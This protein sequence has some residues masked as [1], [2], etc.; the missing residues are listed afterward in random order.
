M[1]TTLL[2]ILILLLS[3]YGIKANRCS[4]AADK[5]DIPHIRMC[6]DGNVTSDRVILDTHEAED[7]GEITCSCIV[8]ATSIIEIYI[9]YYGEGLN[10]N[11]SSCGS[12]VVV[13]KSGSVEEDI[14]YQC[15]TSPVRTFHIRPVTITWNRGSS[16]DSKY[17]LNVTGGVIIPNTTFTISCV[18][19][20]K[21]STP[22][23]TSVSTKTET[24]TR[25]ESTTNNVTISAQESP[26][27]SQRTVSDLGK[28]TTGQSTV[29][30]T[31]S[32]PGNAPPQTGDSLP[33]IIVIPAAAGGLILIIIIIIIVVCCSLFNLHLV[34]SGV[35]F[36]QVDGRIEEEEEETVG[37]QCNYVV[38]ASQDKLQL[39][40]TPQ[41][42]LV[43]T[44][45][46]KALTSPE[47]LDFDCK[48]LPAFELHS[49]IGI[50]STVTL[51]QDIKLY[52]DN[53]TGCTV[54]RAGDEVTDL[55][56]IPRSSYNG[57]D[58]IDR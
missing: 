30:T 21:T 6:E 53:V 33:L 19:P 18:K 10:P 15:N 57:A 37:P 46:S 48:D 36:D 39:N 40:V 45:I 24:T 52:D 7:T 3:V 17:C 35:G 54:K 14:R 31:S 8:N 28:T 51:H 11:T 43:L 12:E 32:E 2:I 26:A 27:T 34:E 4:D 22:T 42:I 20:V 13:P 23:L 56:I 50:H 47:S 9:E 16:G 38:V 58:T 1:G 44:D 5:E 25:T 29:P 41:A 55:Q 49:K